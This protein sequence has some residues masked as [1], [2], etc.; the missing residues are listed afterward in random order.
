M[1]RFT[2][3][4]LILVAMR[5]FGAVGIGAQ[6]ISDF[7]KVNELQQ[8]SVTLND[9]GTAA[10]AREAMSNPSGMGLFLVAGISKYELQVD[11]EYVSKK[12]QAN[13][14]RATNSGPITDKV[15]A[16]SSRLGIS[17]TLKYKL[18]SVPGVTVFT[19]VGVGMQLQTPI[20]NADFVRDVVQNK[21]QEFKLNSKDILKKSNISGF[22]LMMQGRIKPPAVPIGMQVTLRG[23]VI[24]NAKFERPSFVPNL[25]VGLGYFPI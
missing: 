18:V 16:T 8:M 21:D 3:L 22:H 1:K 10:L 25:M 19:G 6:F 5:A 13:L 2:L 9:G 23:L 17:G 15:T 14:I 7:W 24:P 12:Y 20:V 11:A 4:I